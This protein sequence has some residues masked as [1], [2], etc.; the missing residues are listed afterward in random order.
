MAVTCSIVA[1][2]QVANSEGSLYVPSGGEY[3][4]SVVLDLFNTNTTAETTDI[5]KKK[6]G[7]TS[8]LVR[9][10]V[11][12][13]NYAA[14]LEIGDLGPSDDLRALTTTASKVNYVVTRRLKT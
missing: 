10:L 1:E 8:R 11:L 3:A 4:F 7:G 13:A 6:S 14:C 2:G 5:Y 9:R 12:E